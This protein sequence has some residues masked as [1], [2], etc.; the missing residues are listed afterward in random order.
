MTYQLDI[1]D[2]AWF[3]IKQK[4]KRI[5]IRA[6]TNKDKID[7]SKLKKEDIIIFSNS[8]KEKMSCKIKDINWY[9]SIEKLL[10]LEGTKYTLSSTDDYDAGIK[11]INSIKGYQEAIEKFGVYAIHLELC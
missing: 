6:T 11:S 2:R 5:E 4:T 10:T 3:A 8:K 9:D 7:Y 1:N